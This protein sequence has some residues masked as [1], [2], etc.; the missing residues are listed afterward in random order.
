MALEARKQLEAE[1]KCLALD[2]RIRDLVKKGDLSEAKRIISAVPVGD[3]LLLDK[4]RRVLS[5]PVVTRGG[6][7]SG[8]N[9]RKDFSWI[10]QNSKQYRGL[11]I[12][13]KDGELLGSHKSRLALQQDLGQSGLLEG[14]TF[15]K[16]EE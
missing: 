2:V 14:A 8:K 4:W 11:W 3:S 16:V 9:F 1:K 5:D 10:E 15:F 7:A 12:A 13:V 6:P